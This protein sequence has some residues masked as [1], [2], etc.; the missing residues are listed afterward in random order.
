MQEPHSPPVLESTGLSVERG[1]EAADE[2]IF[3]EIQCS[4]SGSGS[5]LTDFPNFTGKDKSDVGKFCGF[6]TATHLGLDSASDSASIC[7][8]WMRDSKVAKLVTRRCLEIA[9]T[10]AIGLGRLKSDRRRQIRIARTSHL[11][12]SY[13]PHLSPSFIRFTQANGKV[14]RT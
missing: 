12:P 14:R 11:S 4:G 8:T 3:F 2:F 5:S 10:S 9:G 1:Y 6:S 7:C 13:S